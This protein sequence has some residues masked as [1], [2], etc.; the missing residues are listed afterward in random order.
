MLADMRSLVAWQG[1]FT[2]LQGAAR[3]EFQGQRQWL[4]W[5]SEL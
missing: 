1:K 3:P 5:L 2:L 4:R